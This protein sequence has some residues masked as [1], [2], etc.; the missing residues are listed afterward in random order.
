MKNETR[1]F[2]INKKIVAM[3]P[4]RRDDTV[5]DAT[6]KTCC[7]IEPRLCEHPTGYPSFEDRK[8]TAKR[9]WFA[10][11][12]IEGISVEQPKLRDYVID[13]AEMPT[14]DLLLIE[15]NPLSNAGIYSCDP[16]Y[17]LKAQL[18]AYGTNKRK[19]KKELTYS[20]KKLS[21]MLSSDK[22]VEHDVD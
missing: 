8:G 9:A 15:L 5:Y 10:R 1:C 16:E 21:V 2:V 11:K 17:I 19:A 22:P 7:R 18:K 13:I 20:I 6:R 4:V 14:G 3:V 12:A